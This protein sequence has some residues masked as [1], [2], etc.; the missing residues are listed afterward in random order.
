MW[1]TLTITTILF[2]PLLLSA[3]D[4][5]QYSKESIYLSGSYFIKNYQQYPLKELKAEIAKSP[6][7]MF[8][9][10]KMLKQRRTALIINAISAASIVTGIFIVNDQGLRNGLI[11]GGLPLIVISDF[12]SDPAQKNLNKA[13]WLR[14]RDVYLIK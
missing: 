13:I 7:A 10:N 1:R 12:F 4:T 9:Y 5:L 6:D 2:I 3:Q 8:Y 11:F 14:N